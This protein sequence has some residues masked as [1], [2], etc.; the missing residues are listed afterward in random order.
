LRLRHNAV[1]MEAIILDTV[2]LSGAYKE[3][4]FHTHVNCVWI[5]F[6]DDEDDEWVGVFGCSG[7]STPRVTYDS[8]KQLALVVVS[9]AVYL[10]DVALRKE[11]WYKEETFGGDAVFIPNSGEILFTDYLKI[12][13]WNH[14][15]EVIWTTGRISWDGVTIESFDGRILRGMLNDLSPKG[16][17]YSFDVATRELKSSWIYQ[18]P[19]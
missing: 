16:V 10:V 12:Q 6:V 19:K 15:G 4:S 9:G 13:I 5:R 7:H 17:P 18:E 8:Q 1:L 14:A 3:V 11:K 2:P